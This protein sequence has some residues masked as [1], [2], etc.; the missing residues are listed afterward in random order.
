MTA[1]LLKNPSSAFLS[2]DNFTV[3]VKTGKVVSD[4][5]NGVCNVGFH[6]PDK[7]HLNDQANIA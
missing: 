1:L 5:N 7:L 2:L 4:I 6:A 3:K